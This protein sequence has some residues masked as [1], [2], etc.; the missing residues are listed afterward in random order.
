[1]KKNFV[2][3]VLTACVGLSATAFAACKDEPQA[4]GM[5]YAEWQ[6]AVAERN[7]L[8]FTLT[9]S[10]NVS[11]YEHETLIEKSSVNLTLKFDVDAFSLSGTVLPDGAEQAN[12]LK[13]TAFD[14]EAEDYRVAYTEL[15]FILL[16][17]YSI[18]DYRAKKQVYSLGK[19]TTLED[20]VIDGELCTLFIEKAT[21]AFTAANKVSSLSCNYTQTS[22]SGYKTVAQMTWTFSG[23][24]L[25][26]LEEPEEEGDGIQDLPSE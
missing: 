16:N 6:K 26:E 7:F 19:A 10:G 4:K 22:E 8:N 2:A 1:M 5:P 18:Y 20:K 17:E 3:L 12:T 21:L 9:Q 13:L 23:Y 11:Q 14:D 15:V 25:T 24:D